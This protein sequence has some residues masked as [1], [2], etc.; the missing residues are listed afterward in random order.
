M[1]KYERQ[2]QILNYIRQREHASIAELS[3]MFH[4]TKVTIRTD[5]DELEKKGLVN[6]THGGVISKEISSFSEIPYEVKSHKRIEEKAKI[7]NVAKNFIKSGDVIILDAGSTTYQLV[8][9]LPEGITVVTTDILIATEIAKTKK[10]IRVLIPA[11][12]LD[13]TVYT[14]KGIDTIKFFETLSVNK[15]FLG[16]DGLDFD[17]GL[18]ER[19]REYAAVKVG[20]IKSASNVILLSDSTKFG[21]KMGTLVCGL[22]KI[23]ILVTDSLPENRKEQCEA[24]GIQ[25]VI[26]K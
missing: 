24:L 11:G 8:Y 25:V 3:D 15:V 2:D 14:I 10:D 18:T 1:Y 6:K 22:D 7:A 12:E 4:V 26:T 13:R 17:F 20:M 5:V 16:C 9:G 21:N 23:N 19:S